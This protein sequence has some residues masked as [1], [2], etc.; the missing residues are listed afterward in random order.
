MTFK[1]QNTLAE[2][3]T[4]FHLQAIP[5][6][7]TNE[8]IKVHFYRKLGTLFQTSSNFLDCG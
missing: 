6:L 4:D 7:H 2:L 3:Q 5:N 1:I 8:I